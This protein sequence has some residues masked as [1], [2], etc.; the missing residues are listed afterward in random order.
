MRL[1]RLTLMKDLRRL[2]PAAAVTSLMLAVLANADRWRADWIAS[3]MEGW[4]NLLLSG[5]WACLAALAVLEDPLVGDRH[6][7]M[8]RPHRWPA[9]LA[10]KVAFALFAIHVPALI[11]DAFVLAARGFSPALY[12]GDLLTRQ[13]LFF[14]CV[15]MPAIAVATLVRSF[16]HFVLALFAVATCIVMLGG[17]INQFSDYS[18]LAGEFRNG[19]LRVLL[20]CA[21]VAV[22]WVQYARR[23]SMAAR[24]IGIAGGLA[25]ASVFAF[26]P[27]RAEYALH[28]S[29]PQIVLGT[30]T[31]DESLRSLARM[32]QQ[33]TT[34]LPIV[35]T[36]GGQGSR[37]RVPF[38]EIEIIGHDGARIRSVR[39]TPNRPFEKIDLMAYAFSPKIE[40][41]PR[42]LV[43]RYSRSAWDRLKNTR[44]AIRGSAGLEFSRA[45]ETTIVPVQGARD[46]PGV[47]RCTTAAV[48]DQLSQPL[49]KVFCESPRSIPASAVMLRHPSTGRVWREGLNLAWTHSPGPNRTWLSPIHR[50]QSFFRLIEKVETAPG[51]QWLVPASYLPSAHIEITPEIVTGRALAHFEFTGVTLSSWHV[52]P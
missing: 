46:V 13:L 25:A 29:V 9:V 27:L 35:I 12:L 2:W 50:G 40:E 51:A 16:T 15:I 22:L 20:V 10:A 6:I 5:A 38:V 32:P 36:P 28:G 49:L 11:A 24:V 52:Q 39:P 4:M 48:Y 45:G 43:L 44:V 34:L 41:P 19:L 30:A 3:P 18:R 14:G 8:T 47:G 1:M 26:L 31:A 33:Q 42:W 23:V 21:A 37:L 17:G 7:W